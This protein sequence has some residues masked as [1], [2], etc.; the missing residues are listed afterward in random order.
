MSPVNSARDLL[1]AD[2]NV[3]GVYGRGAAFENLLEHLNS[4]ITVL[5]ASDGSD[6]ELLRFPPVIS[7]RTIERCGYLHKF[8]QLLGSVHAFVGDDAEHARLVADVETGADWGERQRLTDLALTP[9]ACYAVYPHVAG[10]IPASGRTV[11]VES[12][13]FRQ[14]ASRSLER[15]RAFRMREFVRIGEPHLVH[16]WRDAW[17]ERGETFL[18][19]LGLQTTV[20]VATDAFFGSGARFLAVSQRE[21]GLKFEVIVE[22]DAGVQAAAMSANYHLDHFGGVFGMRLPSGECAH[23]ACVGFGLERLALALLTRHGAAIEDWPAGVRSAL[24]LDFNDCPAG[25]LAR[26]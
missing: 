18:R 1:V 4:A 14:E 13:C 12:W 19:S 6:V 2:P 9:A 25:D 7:R 11:D 22:V 24:R 17:L 5:G 8:P 10:P 15:M 23:T 20:A 21:Q 16:A 26:G 3:L